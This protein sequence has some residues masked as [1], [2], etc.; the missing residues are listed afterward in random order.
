MRDNSDKKQT[1]HHH[2]KRDRKQTMKE[3]GA[4]HGEEHINDG[5]VKD[6]IGMRTFAN[7]S[8][9]ITIRAQDLLRKHMR[10]R[11]GLPWHS[12]YVPQTETPSYDRRY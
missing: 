7:T 11:A 4:E 1:D 9:Y 5:N 8:D 12:T 10:Y 3:I 2:A 6:A